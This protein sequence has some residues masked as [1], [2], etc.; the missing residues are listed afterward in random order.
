[1]QEIV[2]ASRIPP[3]HLKTATLEA[4]QAWRLLASPLLAVGCLLLIACCWV[5]AAD[6]LAAWLLWFALCCSCRPKVVQK[7]LKWV[8]NASK[9]GLK[10]S[11]NGWKIYPGGAQA[12]FWGPGWAFVFFLTFCD[13]IWGCMFGAFGSQ[14]SSN[15]RSK[16]TPTRMR[17][18]KVKMIPKLVNF[19]VQNYWKIN[20]WLFEQSVLKISCDLPVS[21]MNLEVLTLWKS[22]F[23]TYKSVIFEGLERAEPLWRCVL[24]HVKSHEKMST[25]SMN[26]QC[27]NDARKLHL[28]CYQEVPR[29][30]PKWVPKTVQNDVKN[31]AKINVEKWRQNGRPKGS[32]RG[33]AQKNPASR[34]A[35]GG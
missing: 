2:Y 1:M 8:Q 13:A 5:L 11:Q 31:T 10:W 33:K 26:D 32:S 21:Q 30:G 25:K 27:K 4:C 28:K 24:K 22:L 6:C 16:N 14:K 20:G 9:M 3:T 12:A 18:N 35:R 7:G 34:A 17:N 19:G 15:K 23:F 29:N